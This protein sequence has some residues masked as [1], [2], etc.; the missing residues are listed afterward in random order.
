MSNKEHEAKERFRPG[1]IFEGY[2]FPGVL[3]GRTLCYY[4]DVVRLLKGYRRKISSMDREIDFKNPGT[5]KLFSQTYREM[6]FSAVQFCTE[7][8]EKEEC[9]Q[10]LLGVVIRLF[11]K[12]LELDLPDNHNTN[13][14]SENVPWK[15]SQEKIGE[16]Q[17]NSDSSKDQKAGNKED[18]LDLNVSI[19]IMDSLQD[20]FDDRTN[21]NLRN[22]DLEELHHNV[23]IIYLLFLIFKSQYKIGLEDGQEDSQTFEYMRIPVT[24]ETLETIK[25]VLQDC[26]IKGNLFPEV[27]FI[28]NTMLQD[29]IFLVNLYNGPQYYYQDRYGNPLMPD[30]LEKRFLE[31]EGVIDSTESNNKESKKEDEQIFMDYLQDLRT[32]LI[33]KIETLSLQV[34]KEEESKVILESFQLLLKDFDQRIAKYELFKFNHSQRLNS[35][36]LKISKD[37]QKKDDNKRRKIDNDHLLDQSLAE[38]DLKNGE[39]LLPRMSL[40]FTGENKNEY[41]EWKELFSEKH[42]DSEEIIDESKIIYENTV[43]IEEKNNKV[44]D[45]ASEENITTTTLNNNSETNNESQALENSLISIL[46]RIEELVNREI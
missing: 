27:K 9:F 33:Q 16:F 22:T 10:I 7:I 38:I 46:N 35:V 17:A 42:P 32:Q 45:N 13:Y 43:Q 37:I 26:E 39:T 23:T 31:I 44:G 34:Q 19:M 15:I 12:R 41:G 6:K 30:P 28:L 40:P 36:D 1:D 21:H 4:R 24:I 25:K 18:I 29:G 5:F 20:T 3:C 8:E 2:Y 11:N 14:Q